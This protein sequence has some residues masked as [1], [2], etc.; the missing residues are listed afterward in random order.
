MP[1]FGNWL[2][3]I[4][5]G[6][7]DAVFASS[8]IDFDVIRS[9]SDTDFANSALRWVIASVCSRPSSGWTSDLRPTVSL[10]RQVRDRSAKMRFR[11][12]A[13]AASSP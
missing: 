9:L 6:R 13:S 2:A 1:S 5:L 4:G 8:E 7:Y 11:T 3:E 10:R 12:V